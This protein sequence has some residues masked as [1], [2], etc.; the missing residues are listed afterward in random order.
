MLWV[1]A[2]FCALAFSTL[3][4]YWAETKPYVQKPC[5]FCSHTRTFKAYL[6][7]VSHQSWQCCHEAQRERPKFEA[8]RL[9]LIVGILV[10]LWWQNSLWAWANDIVFFASLILLAFVDWQ[11]YVIETWL[12]VLVIL[13]RLAWLV[14][15]QLDALVDFVGAWLIGAGGLYWLSFFYQTIRERVG[16]GEGDPA[17]LGMIGLWVG[18]IDL[19]STIFIASFSGA[20]V[21]WVMLRRQKQPVHSTPIPFVPFLVLG[22]LATYVFQKIYLMP[23]TSAFLKIL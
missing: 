6:P 7:F 19:P 9:L 21:G 17:I 8:L 15:F 3:G 2:L 11:E 23:M 4:L 1:V 13:F 5:R 10:P 14:V 22:G 20:A 18:L 12:V 16:I